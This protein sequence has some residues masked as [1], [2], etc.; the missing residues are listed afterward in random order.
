MTDDVTKVPFVNLILLESF[1]YL[2]K[3]ESVILC[4]HFHKDINNWDYTLYFIH[5]SIKRQITHNL[6]NAI[7]HNKIIT[8]LSIN[9]LT[10][11]DDYNRFNYCCYLNEQ[12]AVYLAIEINSKQ[13]R[14]IYDLFPCYV[15]N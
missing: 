2:S 11:F 6:T 3:K 14:I 8:Q 10:T 15:G 12:Q 7:N 4:S 13:Y 5:S 1:L 9:E